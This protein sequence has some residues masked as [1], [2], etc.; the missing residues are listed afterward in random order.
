M[1]LLDGKFVKD[2]EIDPAKHKFIGTF[3][4][5]HPP[6]SDGSWGVYLCSCGHSLWYVEECFAHWQLGHMDTPQYVTINL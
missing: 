5:P 4:Q 6:V 1:V 3:R 2:K